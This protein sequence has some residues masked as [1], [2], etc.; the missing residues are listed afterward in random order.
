MFFVIIASVVFIIIFAVID[1]KAFKKFKENLIISFNSLEFGDDIKTS[2]EK[3]NKIG[4][5][6]YAGNDKAVITWNFKYSGVFIHHRFEVS[7]R[8]SDCKF[9]EILLNFGFES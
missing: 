1:Y 2:F 5:I 6:Q 8:Y 3:V 7:L 4:L 9:S